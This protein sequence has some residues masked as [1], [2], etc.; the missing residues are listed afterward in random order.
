M[1]DDL[2]E[3]DE[4]EQHPFDRLEHPAVKEAQDDP[5]RVPVVN[6]KVEGSNPGRSARLFDI[7]CDGL[8]HLFIQ[9]L[10]LQTS[11]A[12]FI[13]QELFFAGP[14]LRFKVYKLVFTSL[15]KKLVF[16]GVVKFNPL[17]SVSLLITTYFN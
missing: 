16:S 12:S 3:V 9:L 10:K 13:F 5:V 8:L 17:T 2:D 4:V 7:S 1:N 6:L 15:S 14:T 11:L